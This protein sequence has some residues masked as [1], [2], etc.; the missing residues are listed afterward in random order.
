MSRT[1]VSQGGSLRMRLA[2]L[3][4]LCAGM[5]AVVA[6]V[7]IVGTWMWFE[8]ARAESEAQELAATLAYIAEVPM[9]F[10]DETA[11]REA[12]GMLRVHPDVLSAAIV[13]KQGRQI[14]QY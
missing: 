1:L 3:L 14:A 12:L 5:T 13:D 11:T 10:E 2:A 8:P 4:A 7:A 6:I 9:T